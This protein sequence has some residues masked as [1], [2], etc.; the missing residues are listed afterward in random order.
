MI[1]SPPFVRA[2]QQPVQAGL[3]HGG[4]APLRAV[5][6]HPAPVGGPLLAARDLAGSSCAPKVALDP[7]PTA[8]AVPARSMAR[9]AA[10]VSTVL[11]LGLV[12]GWA[13]LA[14]P[15]RP[16]APP[17]LDT[18]QV[19]LISQAQFMALTA[20]QP[21]V[22]VDLSAALTLPDMLPLPDSLPLP[23][24]MPLPETAQDM[25]ATQPAPM[26]AP[27]PAE[28]PLADAVVDPPPVL[29]EKGLNSASEP[30]PAAAPRAAVA[31]PAP[32]TSKPKVAVAPEVTKPKAQKTKPKSDAVAKPQA[33]KSASPG[34]SL[35]AGQAKTL[36]ADWGSKVRARIN[37]KAA[38]TNGAGTV[39]LRLTLS[40]T[41]ALLSVA[42]VGSA[43]PALDAAALK[44]VKSAAPFPRAPKGLNAA[45]YSFSLPITFAG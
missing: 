17:D 23:N 18:A 25:P 11:H 26:M 29:A 16:L 14:A 13:V 43:G 15:A 45:S 8:M 9:G 5:A 39:K 21:D 2:I 10:L 12:A 35:S 22:A 31:K 36:K 34:A 30:A 1:A 33:A 40:P 28:A 7:R 38:Q 4:R 42:V 6:P 41:G 19:E 3:G 27:A 32:E 37:R 44:A 24:A 20:P